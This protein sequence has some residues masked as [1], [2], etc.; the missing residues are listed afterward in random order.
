MHQRGPGLAGAATYAIERLRCRL[1]G[2]CVQHVPQRL[3][4][5]V[6]SVAI[7]VIK[8]VVDP[9]GTKSKTLAHPHKSRLNGLAMPS[10]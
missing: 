4:C 2:R 10:D 3:R 1:P 8:P 9:R 7:V 6:Q 5:P